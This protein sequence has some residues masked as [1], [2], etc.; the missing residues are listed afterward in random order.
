MTADNQQERLDARWVRS[1]RDC[2]SLLVNE[3]KDKTAFSRILRDSTPEIVLN[4]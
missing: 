1:D 4:D 3:Q 2:K